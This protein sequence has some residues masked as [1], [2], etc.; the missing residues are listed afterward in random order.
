MLGIAAAGPLDPVREYNAVAEIDD[1]GPLMLVVSRLPPSQ[2][3]I[4]RIQ[5]LATVRVV[6]VT[7]GPRPEPADD[8]AVVAPLGPAAVDE[9]DWT[10]GEVTVDWTESKCRQGNLFLH[11]LLFFL[12]LLRRLSCVL[13]IFRV[14]DGGLLAREEE[15]GIIGRCGGFFHRDILEIGEIVASVGDG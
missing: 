1:C 10:D 7:R 6:A 2:R 13:Q 8:L 11:R 14:P 5:I 9:V 12:L 15:D 4:D 3:R